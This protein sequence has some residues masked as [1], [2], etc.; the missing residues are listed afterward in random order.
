ML[1]L[2]KVDAEVND[3]GWASVGK[4]EYE[5]YS[6]ES[7][8]DA[9]DLKQ[10]IITTPMTDAGIEVVRKKYYRYWEGTFDDT[11]NPGYPHAIKYVVDFEGTRVQDWEDS[12]FDEDYLLL[13]DAALEDYAAA[14]FEYDSSHRIDLAWFEGDCGCG[15]NNGTHEFEYETN[16]SFTDTPGTYQPSW[17]TRTVVKRPDLAYLTQYYEEAGQALARVL[18]DDDPDNTSPAPNTWVWHADRD[19]DGMVE[20]MAT[21][22]NVSSYTHSSGGISLSSSNGLYYKYTRKG[23]GFNRGFMTQRKWLPGLGS[24]N[25]YFEKRWGYGQIDLAVGD[26]DVVRPTQI[27]LHT[28]PTQTTTSSNKVTT[29]YTVTAYSGELAIES[30]ETKDPAVSTSKNGSGT[31][32][33][34]TTYYRKD[35]TVAFVEARDGIISYQEYSDGRMTESIEDADTSQTSDFDITVPSGLASSGVEFHRATTYT[36]DDQGRRDAT[37]EPDG[38]VLK[39]YYSRLADHR[40]VALAYNDYETSPSTKFYGPVF[41]SASNHAG[42]AEVQAT[43]ALT[44]NEST[45]ALTAHVD[46][47]DHD[48]ITAMDLGEVVRLTTSHYDE[49]AGKLTE[50]RLYFDVPASGAGAD[51]TN[52]DPTL[53]V[54]DDMGRQTK[55]TEANGTIY[56]STYDVHGRV[57]VREIGTDDSGGGTD[58]MVTVELA[59]YDDGNDGE[60]GFLTKRTLRV[61]STSTNERVTTFDHDL[62]GR[63]LL[64]TRPESPHAFHKYDNEGRRLATGLFSLVGSINVNSDDPTTETTNRVAL[65]E[66]EYDELGRAWKSTR[67]KIDASDGS[68]DDSLD[69]EYWRD[70]VGRSIKQDADQLAKTTYD[71]LGRATHQFTLAEDNDTGYSDAD[72]VSGDYVVEEA[73]SAY[74]SSSDELLMSVFIQREHDDWGGGAT[75]GA[76]DSNADADDLLV[77]AANVSGRPQITAFW[78]DR[79]GRQTDAVRYGTYGGSNFDRDGLTV[80]SRSDTALRTSTS[81]GTDGARQDVTDP[82]DLVT[83]TE[84][85]DAGRTTKV[86]RN[87]DASVNNGNPSGTDDNQTVKYEYTDGLQTKLIVDVPAGGTDQE[88][89]YTYGT[90]SGAGVG[91]SVI[92]TGYLLQKVKYPD[93]AG[94]SDVVT[95]AYNAQAQET[96]RKDQAGNVFETEHDDDGREEHLRVTTL[97]ADFDGAVRRISTSYDSSG[98]PELITQ[99]DNATVGSG[100]V[101]DEVKYTYDGWGGVTNFEQDKNSAVGASGSVD[102]Y[103]VSYSYAKATTGRNTVR[104][105]GM[106]LPSGNVITIDYSLDKDGSLSRVSKLIDGATTL[107]EYDYLGAGI[108]AGTT[109]QEPEVY[110]RWFT[111]SGYDNIDRFNRVTSDLWSMDIT[112]PKHFY[113]IELNYDRSSSVTIAEDNVHPGFDVSYTIDDLDR[114]TDAQEGTWSGSSITSE[115][116]QQEWTLSHTG[117]WDI[118]KLDLNGDGDWLDANEHEDDR[119]HNKANELTARDTDD[120]GTDD[121][122][123]AYDEAGNLTDDNESY[124]YVYDPF[125]RLRKITNQSGTT[126]AEYRYNGL[127]FQLGRLEDTDADGDADSS[128]KWFYA[129]FDEAWRRLS[130]FRESDSDPK[131]EFVCSLAGEDGYGRSSHTNSVVLREKDANTAWTAASDGTLEQ[132]HYYCHNSG[133]SLVALSRFNGALLQWIKYSSY[134]VPFGLPGADTDSDGDCLATDGDISQLQTW[135]DTSVYDVRGD[136]DLDGDVDSADKSIA[137]SVLDG[138]QLGWQVLSDE[139]VRRAASGAYQLANASLYA[140]AT[141]TF[142]VGLGRNLSRERNITSPESYRTSRRS[143]FTA[144]ASSHVSGPELVDPKATSAAENLI[145]GAGGGATPEDCTASGVIRGRASMGKRLTLMARSSHGAETKAEGACCAELLVEVAAMQSEHLP[146][147]SPPCSLEHAVSLGACTETVQ[148]VSRTT[149]SYVL[150]AFAPQPY[151]RYHVVLK[152]NMTATTSWECG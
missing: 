80:P 145:P 23:S 51:G 31:R 140:A 69:S 124:K 79:F 86:I 10:V 149:L 18:T 88:T 59:E 90:T 27:A 7:H 60:N 76:L 33:T 125:G 151:K 117:N 56:R 9:G 130:L 39:S 11:T 35:G 67:H 47:T 36:Y 37:T 112:T 57:V 28:Y 89:E 127:G 87:Y 73:Q 54:Y 131:E 120:D 84:Y 115:T 106:T 92:A 119:T 8:G 42:K 136:V 65:N 105:T 148:S 52:Y 138:K 48:P 62:R 3:S 78:Y 44:S 70:E 122:L 126:I 19:S 133:G 101:V 15:G 64:E 45:A 6:N 61:E 46:E 96:Y 55:T 107:V 25:E 103:E 58:N 53:Y 24:L 109:Y 93:S 114:L 2:T 134:G 68:D 135:V 21:P 128:D 116:R 38:R 41:Y 29:N 74:D 113:N 99:Y 63:V 4:V 34:S 143:S 75:T 49:T 137:E 91:D 66:T 14:Y 85:D 108:V 43:V 17:K 141:E 13:T 111:A 5:Y 82:R 98:R 102:D 150:G 152:C 12:T 142:H 132:R 95:Y 129:A 144:A 77:T 22:S 72:D 30:I 26:S 81:Y 139:G 110:S 40:L 118:A 32:N 71:R 123:L 100:T 94:G 121:Y 83:R 104:R 16:G 147:C 50:S 1:R 97:D 146:N 20:A